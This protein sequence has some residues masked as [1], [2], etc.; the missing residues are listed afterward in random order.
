[1]NVLITGK[2]YF[3]HKIKLNVVYRALLVDKKVI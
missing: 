3:K 1:M 2:V